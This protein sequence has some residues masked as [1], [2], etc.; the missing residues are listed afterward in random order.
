MKRQ[1]KTNAQIAEHYGVSKSGFRSRMA[2]LRSAGKLPVDFD[3]VFAVPAKNTPATPSDSEIEIDNLTGAHKSR[4]LIEMSEED[5]KNPEFVMRKHGYDANSWILINHKFKTF[6]A[7][8]T[9]D[10]VL[11]LYSSHITVKPR[12]DEWRFED[13][14]KAAKSAPP[15]T[16]VR[17]VDVPQ[18]RMLELFISDPHFGV[19][20]LS[21]YLLTQARI[22][23]LIE[24]RRWEEILI[25]VGSDLLH[26]DTMR[27]TTSS[28]TQIEKV[29]MVQAWKDAAMFYDPLIRSALKWSDRVKIVYVPG[30]HDEALGFAF[31]QYLQARYPQVEY[32][33]AFLMRKAH[34]YHG[35]FI[36]LTH[37][38]KGRNRLHNIF[39][40]EFAE[41]WA[42]ATVREVHIGHLHVEDAK[43]NFGMMIRTLATRNKTDDWHNQMGFVGNHKRFMIF[44]YSHNALEAIHYV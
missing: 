17:P 15:I 25:P 33:D 11:T 27:G 14:L 18:E 12:G 43:D 26:N 1:G 7:Y 10:G 22:D 6:N 29:D 9:Q 21:D 23:A 4:R 44:E 3:H 35:V 20:T 38:D 30:N 2:E 8:S 5:A 19:S 37:G 16:V 32:D 42:H 24:S 31:V 39:P 34:L 36:G 13:L 41:M 28:G 40:V